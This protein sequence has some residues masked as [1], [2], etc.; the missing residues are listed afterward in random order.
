[1][2][3]AVVFK[4]KVLCTSCYRC[5][6]SLASMTPGYETHSGSAE[7]SSS[8]K[9]PTGQPK[10]RAK[11]RL[12]PPQDPQLEFLKQIRNEHKT[13]EAERKQLLELEERKAAERDPVDVFFEFCALRV[14][15]LPSRT[16]SIVEMQIQQVL[17]NAENPASRQ[18]IMD[19]PPDPLPTAAAPPVHSGIQPV[20]TQPV[21]A[22]QGYL[23]FNIDPFYNTGLPSSDCRG[24]TSMVFREAMNETNKD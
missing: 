17:F 5:T 12:A 10:K 22:G 7:G 8:G 2:H 1:M 13:R 6:S 11:R 3:F 24:E 19:L 4:C 21:L 18:K 14:K 15:K 16:R 23:G 9:T 20:P